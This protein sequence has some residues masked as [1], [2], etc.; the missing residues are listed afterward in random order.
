[1]HRLFVLVFLTNILAFNRALPTLAD[2]TTCSPINDLA[3]RLATP[4]LL[5]VGPTKPPIHFVKGSDKQL[6]CPNPRVACRDLAF[7]VSG[8][9]VIVSSV[10][11]D[12]MC[13]AY[14][15]TSGKFT[16][17]YGWLPSSVLITPPE[18]G[19][20]I[21]D[22]AGWIGDWKTGADREI[23]IKLAPGGKVS[24]DVS[25]TFAGRPIGTNG[26]D[27]PG[28]MA[29][30]MINGD[31]AAFSLNTDTGQIGPLD[32]D[33]RNNVLCRV[34]LWRLGKYLVAVDNGCGIPE[35]GTAT[36][37]YRMVSQK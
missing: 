3:V 28:Y 15:A 16:T 27:L 33:P 30:I 1:M 29:T 12:Y 2:D 37:V 34:R 10:I 13:V 19:K 21:G 35:N 24:L 26:K 9:D 7:V 32:A 6:G 36:G 18:G 5:S 17:S 8:D 22:N 4:Q 31:H 14:T 11:K 23:K 25:S 20:L